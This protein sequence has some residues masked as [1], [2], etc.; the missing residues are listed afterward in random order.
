MNAENCF[1]DTLRALKILS[2]AENTKEVDLSTFFFVSP[3]FL[4]PI[5]I[6]KKEKIIDKII[7]PNSSSVREYLE[8]IS[9]P[10]GLSIKEF[11]QASKNKSYFPLFCFSGEEITR[12]DILDKILNYI[13]LFV[14]IR[15]N[16][17]LIS[18]PLSEL[19]DN[20]REHAYSDNCFINL[21]IY[22]GG[23]L[24]LSLADKGT[25]IP[26]SYRNSGF[27][28]KNDSEAFEF[29][30]SGISSTKDST[31]G[32]GLNSNVQI[33]SE[34]LK[35]SIVIVSG[36][37]L[38]LK[39]SEDKPVIYDLEDN[40]LAFEGTIVNM[41]FKIPKK[42]IENMYKFLGNKKTYLN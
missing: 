36:K 12:E 4:T 32:Y 18:Q 24:A 3:Y 29:I 20:I 41:F 15:P 26:Q 21:Q 38:L 1:K 14:D 37:G 16:K 39:N 31:R 22:K 17:S 8:I 6:L 13:S 30:L 7:L 40:K 34:A 42:K 28:L 2:K 5:S 11:R 33:I 23:Y 10:D 9:F 35:G 25:T 19:I 27:K